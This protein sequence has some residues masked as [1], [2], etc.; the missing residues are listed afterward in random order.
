MRTLWLAALIA[1]ATVLAP[2]TAHAQ[3]A[4]SYPWCIH[5]GGESATS[6]CSFRSYQ[7]CMLSVANSSIAYC[8]RNPAYSGRQR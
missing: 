6:S 2:A 8:Y 3:S 1:T 5:D 4:S 7:Q